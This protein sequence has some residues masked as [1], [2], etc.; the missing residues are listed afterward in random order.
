[1]K[2][3]KMRPYI[4]NDLNVI[5]QFNENVEWVNIFSAGNV[6]KVTQDVRKILI[7]NNYL[8]PISD[9]LIVTFKSQTD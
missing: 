8:N 2:S 4:K 5:N 9:N 3:L 1:M 6:N 7:K